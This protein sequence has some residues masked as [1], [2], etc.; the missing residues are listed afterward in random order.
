M[1]HPKAATSAVLEGIALLWLELK[2]S[3][4]LRIQ[5][6]GVN[7]DFGGENGDKRIKNAKFEKRRTKMCDKL[8]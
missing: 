8:R 5:G 3:L 1:K 7:R 4:G 2:Y 6:G